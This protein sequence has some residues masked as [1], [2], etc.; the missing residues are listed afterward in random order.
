MQNK[1]YFVKGVDICVDIENRYI[2]EKKIAKYQLRTMQLLE[3]YNTKQ[4]N[5]NGK[6]VHTIVTNVFF[7]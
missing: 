3:L 5:Y 2:Y 6:T 7:V 1:H 4:K